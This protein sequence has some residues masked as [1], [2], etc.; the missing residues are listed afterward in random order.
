MALKKA[1][2]EVSCAVPGLQVLSA[3]EDKERLIIKQALVSGSNTT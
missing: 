3:I 2:L 1:G